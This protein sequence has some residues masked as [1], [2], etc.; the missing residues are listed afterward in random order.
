MRATEDF[1]VEDDNLGHTGFT[2]SFDGIK[3]ALSCQT[4]CMRAVS[5][6][7]VGKPIVDAAAVPTIHFQHLVVET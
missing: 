3:K 2:Q 1:G 7:V 6:C 4:L 5:N